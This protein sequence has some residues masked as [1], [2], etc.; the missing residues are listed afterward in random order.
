MLST[1][2]KQQ[3]TVVTLDP[4]GR[5]QLARELFGFNP[6]D[7]RAC[8]TYIR[9]DILYCGR[10]IYSHHRFI[11]TVGDLR[12]R[13]VPPTQGEIRIPIGMTLPDIFHWIATGNMEQRGPVLRDGHTAFLYGLPMG[14]SY[15]PKD[16]I[17]SG[18]PTPN[19]RG[20]AELAW[21]LIAVVE[22]S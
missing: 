13:G 8:N 1:E 12:L 17:H 9:N 2:V 11:V 16:R 4:S 19:A 6:I 7:L 18:I 21:E 15:R 14:D 22:K 20:E 5:V 3:P 10:Y